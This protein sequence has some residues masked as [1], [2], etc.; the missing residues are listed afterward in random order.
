MT[1]LSPSI[2]G[3][4]DASQ[5]AVSFGVHCVHAEVVLTC[6]CGCFPAVEDVDEAL[7]Q[8]E[9]VDSLKSPAHFLEKTVHNRSASDGQSPTSRAHKWPL[10][11]VDEER[12]FQGG[13]PQEPTPAIIREQS[14]TVLS[15]GLACYERVVSCR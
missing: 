2:A 13:T 15:S 7:K 8:L 1:S 10:H 6:F 14:T 9:M 4:A 12:V 5:S 11:D 3:L